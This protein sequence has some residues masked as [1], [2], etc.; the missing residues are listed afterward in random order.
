MVLAV[1]AIYAL[2]STGDADVGS[3]AGLLRGA[4][5]V[6]GTA[7]GLAPLAAAA[8]RANRR[9][10]GFDVALDAAEGGLRCRDL[11]GDRALTARGVG[12]A[13]MI[14]RAYEATLVITLDEDTTWVLDLENGREAARVREALG[15]TTVASRRVRL[16]ARSR[17]GGLGCARIAGALVVTA[18]WLLRGLVGGSYSGGL[19]L[20]LGALI[21]LV[22]ITIGFAA[23]LADVRAYETITIGEREVRIE[24]ATGG[25]LLAP[26][27]VVK[28]GD[29]LEIQSENRGPVRLFDAGL[30]SV[31]LLP[32]LS[33]CIEAA[34]GAPDPADRA[35]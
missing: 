25:R 30:M 18:F 11:W 19:L 2:L 31:P 21:A 6:L 34:G 14:E 16:T 7:L 10:A 27:R 15:L 5:A 35:T 4:V 33:R 9:S 13:L 20:A 29:E 28:R 23:E 24:R 8:H 1:A 26:F 3:R 17:A 32:I 22:P 12:G